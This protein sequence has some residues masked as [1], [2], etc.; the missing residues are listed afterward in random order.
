MMTVGTL[1]LLYLLAAR[2]MSVILLGMRAGLVVLALGAISMMLL[3]L[4]GYSHFYPQN[5]HPN[6]FGTVTIFR[7]NYTC[8]GAFLTLTCGK[9]IKGLF[10]SLDDQRLVA[11][12]MLTARP[13]CTPDQYRGKKHLIANFAQEQK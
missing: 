8:V 11:E 2:V 4:T 5:A 1:N 6:S 3:G 13:H 7:L 12:A 9:L 10:A